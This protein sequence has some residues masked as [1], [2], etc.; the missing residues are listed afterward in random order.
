MALTGFNRHLGPGQSL[1][2]AG[3]SRCNHD[4]RRLGS[5][6]SKLAK[7]SSPPILGYHEPRWLPIVDRATKYNKVPGHRPCD[8]IHDV[9][10]RPVRGRVGDDHP[11]IAPRRANERDAAHRCLLGHVE[12]MSRQK[13]RYAPLRIVQSRR[14]CHQ[15]PREG[16]GDQKNKQPA[17]RGGRSHVA[18]PA[19]KFRMSYRE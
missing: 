10:L 1:S 5:R 3:K 12:I 9:A 7:K 17:K 4:G 14:L 11:A 8:V 15:L 2:A 19:G 16:R 6:Y 18:H 13:S